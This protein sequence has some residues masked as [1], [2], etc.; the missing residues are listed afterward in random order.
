MIESNY[1]PYVVDSHDT[2]FVIGHYL[3]SNAKELKERFE[4]KRMI[5]YQHEPLVENHWWSTETIIKNLEGADEVWDY[6]LENIKILSKY[7][8]DAKYR[9]PVYTEELK[10]VKNVD[11]PDID[12]LFYGSPTNRRM[13]F[14]S[15]FITVLPINDEDREVFTKMSVVNTFNVFGE[16]LDELIGR[17]K[18]ILN[19]NPYDG[20]CRQQQTR[21]FNA[22]IN[23]KCVL[24]EANRFNYYGNLI[25]EFR[26]LPDFASKVFDLLREDKW[27][28]YTNN[29]YKQFSGA[30]VTE[31][32]FTSERAT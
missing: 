20:E 23:N 11:N 14:L 19:T 16:K 27:K 17:S 25:V 15:D 4:A 12:L 24:S 26:G 6:D 9:P 18:I 1:A 22:L 21:I 29:N 10:T 8:I 32:M 31:N 28:N 13:Q 5:V 2:Y 30:R 3:W 7:G